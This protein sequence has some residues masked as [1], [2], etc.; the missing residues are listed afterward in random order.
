M[1]RFQEGD[2]EAFQELMRRY[3]DP[4]VSFCLRMLNDPD[5]A[6]DVAQETFVRVF[7]HAA[8]YEPLASF[9][10]WLYRIAYNLSINE[11]R[12]RLRQPT[13]SLDAP[14]RGEEE[15]MPARE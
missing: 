13:V 4:I 1:R 7:T 6:M 15:P 11:I 2:E 10:G 3:R 5:Q 8:S 9:T 12:R 14:Q